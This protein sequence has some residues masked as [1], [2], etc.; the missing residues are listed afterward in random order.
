MSNILVINTYSE[1]ETYK[2]GQKIG[3]EIMGKLSV[4]KG[5]GTKIGFMGDLGAGKTTII[6]GIM[7]VLAPNIEATSP[8]Y[9]IINEYELL[10][11]RDRK[12][13]LFHSDLYRINEEK[14]LDGTG[15]WEAIKDPR[16]VM[17][18]EWIDRLPR[19]GHNSVLKDSSTIAISYGVGDYLENTGTNMDSRREIII[20]DKGIF[21]YDQN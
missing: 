14:D 6:K 16:A 19:D 1:T 17:F 12:Y 18:I 4:E 8:T 5:L 2:I 21:N 11:N 7:S 3:S 9:T 13:T 20:R 15:F 10:D